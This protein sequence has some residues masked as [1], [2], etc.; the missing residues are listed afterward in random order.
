LKAILTAELTDNDGWLT[1]AD[2][3]E[4]LGHTDTAEAFRRALAEE[5]DHLARV[6]SWLTTALEGQAGLEPSPTP[7]EPSLPASP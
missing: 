5:E 4:R 6:R 2:M 1:L 3:A 7:D